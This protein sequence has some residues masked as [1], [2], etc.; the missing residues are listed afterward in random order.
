MMLFYTWQQLLSAGENFRDTLKTT[1]G[2]W[3]DLI[4]AEELKRNI[5]VRFDLFQFFLWV[6]EKRGLPS[7]VLNP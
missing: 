7:V 1:A 2:T 6:L 4:G 3:K 5:Y